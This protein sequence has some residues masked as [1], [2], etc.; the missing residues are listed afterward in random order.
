MGWQ[1]GK[2]VRRQAEEGE[3]VSKVLAK[4]GDEVFEGKVVLWP[5]AL[6]FRPFSG[7][8]LLTYRPFAFIVEN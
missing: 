3:K 6:G 5:G 8:G 2:V 1:N 4:Y 7:Y